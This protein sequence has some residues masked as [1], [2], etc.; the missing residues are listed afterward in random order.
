MRSVRTL[1]RAIASIINVLDPE[2]VVLGG[3]IAQ[4]GPALFDPLEAA[5]ASDEWRLAGEAVP[6]IP[7]S[8]GAIAGA[9]GAAHHALMN[10]PPSTRERRPTEG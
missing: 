8:L 2:V 5:L 10:T 1:S 3:G 9:I 6:V 7:A 4:A